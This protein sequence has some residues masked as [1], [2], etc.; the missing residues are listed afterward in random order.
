MQQAQPGM[1]N[2]QAGPR[3]VVIQVQRVYAGQ[4]VTTPATQPATAP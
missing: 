4:P 1:M 2:Q 3:R